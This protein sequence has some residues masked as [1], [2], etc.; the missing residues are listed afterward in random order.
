MTA[1]TDYVDIDTAR[2]TR[3]LR[4]V[5]TR[6]VPGPWGESA[7][8]MFWVKHIPYSRVAQEAGGA[9]EA[10]IAWTGRADAP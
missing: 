3:G 5:L 9:N 1:A 4:L 6:G 7:K 2:A 10:L 8:G